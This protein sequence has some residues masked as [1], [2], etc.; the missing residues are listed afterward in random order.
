MLEGGVFKDMS[1]YFVLGYRHGA[2]VSYSPVLD[3]FNR[4][5]NVDLFSIDHDWVGPADSLQIMLGDVVGRLVGLSGA[6]MTAIFPPSA[7]GDS[8][9]VVLGP[10]DHF[11][12]LR[13]SVK[14]KFGQRE[15]FIFYQPISFQ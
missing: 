14:K 5:G 2:S 11:Y 15:E 8:G 9:T 3:D 6:E 13:H 10:D 1:D 7:K 4:D 12:F